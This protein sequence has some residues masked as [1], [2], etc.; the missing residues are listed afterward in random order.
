MSGILTH[1]KIDMA[2]NV[3]AEWKL[4]RQGVG[5]SESRAQI[6]GMRDLEVFL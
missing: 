3:R 6:E 4:Y 2:V 1:T 5:G